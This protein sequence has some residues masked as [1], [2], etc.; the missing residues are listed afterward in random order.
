MF[1]NDNKHKLDNIQLRL[2][3]AILLFIG[4]YSLT[5]FD[6]NNNYS[7]SRKGTFQP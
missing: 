4:Q 1:A 7:N 2:L 3:Q 6:L 5:Y